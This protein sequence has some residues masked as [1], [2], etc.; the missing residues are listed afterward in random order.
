MTSRH[1]T[2]LM[3]LVVKHL[4][5]QIVPNRL[6]TARV[7]VKRKAWGICYDCGTTGQPF[8]RL[9]HPAALLGYH[10][11]VA[12]YMAILVLESAPYPSEEV[13]FRVKPKS[14][15]VHIFV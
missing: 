14:R 4:Q 5:V 1:Q 11:A 12:G 10:V 7:A 13:N 9:N 6:P 8:Y 15:L 2:S 3:R